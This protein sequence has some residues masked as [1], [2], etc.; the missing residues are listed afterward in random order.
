MQYVTHS[1]NVLL[2][3][4]EFSYFYDKCVDDIPEG[5]CDSKLHVVPWTL[6]TL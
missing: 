1:N 2:E 6:L 3:T 4:K 5:D